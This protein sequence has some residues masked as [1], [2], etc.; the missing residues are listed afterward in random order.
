MISIR[1]GELP[2]WQAYAKLLLQLDSL[3]SVGKGDTPEADAI[4]D[5]MD[6]PWYAMSEQEL[7]RIRG[8]SEDLETLAAGGARSVAMSRE[9]K[10]QWAKEARAA[11]RDSGNPDVALACLRR[12]FPQGMPAFVIPFLQSRCW[13]S[14]G[15][16]EVALRFMR[17]AER[18]DPGHAICVLILLDR[19]GQ[20][21][22][23]EKYANRFL[24]IF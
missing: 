18:I 19:L 9:K 6:E 3:L 4:R 21:E 5:E 15:C 8:L 17:E 24:G 14:L 23:A 10:V 7:A 1:T 12:P 2:A 20:Q 11:L 22:E 13:E 16:L